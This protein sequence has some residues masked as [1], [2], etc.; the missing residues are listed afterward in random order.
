MNLYTSW[1]S[2]VPPKTSTTSDLHMYPHN[3]TTTGPRTPGTSPTTRSMVS[4]TPGAPITAL[5]ASVPLS[6]ASIF[7]TG[8]SVLG[9]SGPK[10]SRL[11]N[12]EAE[13]VL[14]RKFPGWTF[15]E[16]QAA[17]HEWVWQYGYDISCNSRR[18]FV[19][20]QC[21]I[22]RC[23]RVESFV[24]TGLQNAT[25]HLFEDHRIRAPE[26][27]TKPTAEKRA[28]ARTTIIPRRSIL[29]DLQLNPDV[30]RDQ[31]IANN[32]IKSF[33]QEHFQR[34]EAEWL[35]D[36]QLPFTTSQNPRF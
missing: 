9:P 7:A 28:E 32:I 17:H 2:L 3:P 16:R 24:A 31:Q 15:S 25:K 27:G 5:N 6:N 8:A 11:T 4:T 1:D 30:L 34:L 35:I 12:K 33:N 10:P 20:K 19:C 26:G 18:R 14:W 21:I 22:T 36:A 29:E 13:A 23:P